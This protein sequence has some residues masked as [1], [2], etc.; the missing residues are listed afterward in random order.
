M[1]INFPRRR[2][3][4]V[5]CMGNQERKRVELKEKRDVL[6]ILVSASSKER[7]KNHVRDCYSTAMCHS[8]G[9]A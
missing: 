4:A 9:L 8:D 6:D 7:T 2:D 3:M 1:A 5:L